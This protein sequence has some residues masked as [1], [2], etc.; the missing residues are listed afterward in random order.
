MLLDL[1]DVADELQRIAQPLFAAQQNR[2]AR[3]RRTG[4]A[5][6]AQ[7][8]RVTSHGAPT[9]FEF[10]PALGELAHRQECEGVVEM[11]IR[12]V[13]LQLHGPS[14]TGQRFVQ[15][16]LSQQRIAQIAVRSAKSGWRASARR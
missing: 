16:V 7:I 2:A 4:P 8:R 9:P 15:L 11:C 6:S 5:G 14:A 13:G 12:I 10:R 1:I 3:Q